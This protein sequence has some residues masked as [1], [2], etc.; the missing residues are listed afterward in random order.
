MATKAKRPKNPYPFTR[1]LGRAWVEGYAARGAEVRRLQRE[2]R[3]ATK[4][5]TCFCGHPAH[6]GRQCAGTA[7][8]DGFVKPC[9]CG[10][11]R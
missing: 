6:S 7:I 5:V 3:A 9:P 2:L 1:G 10:S 4:E 8:R 11:G